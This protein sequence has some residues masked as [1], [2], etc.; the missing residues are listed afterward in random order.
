MQGIAQQ[1]IMMNLDLWLMEVHVLGFN[2][3]LLCCRI[4]LNLTFYPMTPGKLK[5]KWYF[6]APNGL[7]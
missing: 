4:L 3:Y 7:F 1:D 5:K 6:Q 2:L